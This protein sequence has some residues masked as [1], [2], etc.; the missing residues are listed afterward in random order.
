MNIDV[1]YIH[2]KI[3]DPK[4]G[5]NQATCSRAQRSGS[6]IVSLTDAQL[7]KVLSLIS[8]PRYLISEHCNKLTSR[9]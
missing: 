4:L 7:I 5:V 3:E 1:M 8:F 2:V 6:G 9:S